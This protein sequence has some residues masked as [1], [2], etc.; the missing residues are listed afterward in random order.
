MELAAILSGTLF[1]GF[2][3]GLIGFWGGCKAG[4]KRAENGWRVVIPTG[5]T[6]TIGREF[7]QSGQCIH[8]VSVY[9]QGVLNFGTDEKNTFTSIEADPTETFKVKED[10]SANS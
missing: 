4:R 3:A 2:L 7:V 1:G 8:T 5:A 6:L 10:Q 9:G